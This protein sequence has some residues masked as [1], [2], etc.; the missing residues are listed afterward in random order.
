MRLC[1]FLGKRSAGPLVMLGY[2]PTRGA[3]E[4]SMPRVLL[5]DKIYPWVAG[6]VL[7]I[8]ILDLALVWSVF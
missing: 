1:G 8:L 2:R 6:L 4:L 7:A 3:G 5:G